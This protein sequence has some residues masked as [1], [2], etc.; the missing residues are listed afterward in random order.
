MR[1]SKHFRKDVIMARIIAAL[2]L[3][4]LIA[5]ISLGVSLLTKPSADNNKDSQNTHNTQD[6]NPGNQNSEDLDSEDETQDTEDL[7]SEENTE[8]LS[9]EDSEVDDSNDDTDSEEKIY[10]K[11][12]TQVKLRKEPNTECATLDRIDGDTKL[13]VLETLEGW[14][15]VSYNGQ[16]GYVSATYANVVEE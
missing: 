10:V 6:V 13:E 2:I 9:T 14:Y 3:I 4:V 1:K 16:V 5:L 15:K 8:D 12:T 7:S 11:T